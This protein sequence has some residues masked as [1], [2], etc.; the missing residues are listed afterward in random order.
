[1]PKRRKSP[2][3]RFYALYDKVYRADVLAHA[4]ALLPGQR[5][6]S[7]AWTARR[8]RTSRSTAWSGGWANWRKNS[9]RRRIEPQPV[10]RVYIPK[11]DGKT[12]AVGHSDDPGPRGADG[13]GAGPGADLRG[14]PAAGAIRLPA[15]AQR[16]GRGAGG[17]RACWST[18]HRE[19][20][21]RGLERVLRQHSA[22]GT[23]EVGGAARQ[24]PAAA[25]SDQDV[26]G[27]A[28][29]RDRRAGAASSRTTRNKDEERGTPQGAPISPLLANLYMR[30]FVLGWKTLGHEQRLEA[31]IVNYADDFVICCR[32]TAEEA[33]AAMRDMMAAAEADGERDEDARLCRV[34]EETFDFLGYTFGRCYS[35]ADGQRPT[36]GTRPCG[37]RVVQRL[38]RRRSAR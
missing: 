30:R 14:R 1:M 38:L 25:A 8:S 2:D 35:R 31:H 10:R 32:G 9:G 27:G 21:G 18:G 11:P 33:M 17:P 24:R 13:G 23:D 5:R 16:A 26:A 3:F 22:R 6:G 28:G 37:R 15:G 29:G 36:L 12:A 34:P 7:R 4:Y 19:G 20:G